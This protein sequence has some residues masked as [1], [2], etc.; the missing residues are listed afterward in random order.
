VFF[1]N[2]CAS[3]F[4][5]GCRALWAGADAACNIHAAGPHHCPWCA[6]NP[7]WAY[8]AMIVPQAL[9]SFWPSQH[10]W[11]LRLLAALVAFPFFG[12]I[13]AIIYGTASGYW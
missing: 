6:H 9:I 5:C 11:R 3:V 4:R 12:G 10:A 8:L 13:A 7:S 2:F 1:I